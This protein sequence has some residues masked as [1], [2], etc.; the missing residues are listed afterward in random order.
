MFYF[1]IM[2]KT[3]ITIPKIHKGGIQMALY[4]KEYTNEDYFIKDVQLLET[5][6]IDLENI[7]VLTHDRDRTHRLAEQ[8]E[9]NTIGVNEMGVGN[10]VSSMFKSEGDELRN[11]LKEMGLTESE[12]TILEKE[13]DKGKVIMMVQSNEN[14]HSHLLP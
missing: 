12:A 9:I 2:G 4:T 1:L 5:K 6:G 14:V 10:A 8:A 7:Y 13:L 3:K 11:K